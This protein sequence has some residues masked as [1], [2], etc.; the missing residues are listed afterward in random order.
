M[1]S[2]TQTRAHH[3]W[4]NFSKVL[5][6]RGYGGLKVSKRKLELVII[7]SETFSP[8]S[9]L[10]FSKIFPRTSA[11]S[12]VFRRLPGSSPPTCINCPISVKEAT[13]SVMILANI[14]PK[15]SGALGASVLVSSKVVRTDS[16]LPK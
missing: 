8:F 16:K 12:P 6:F 4:M 9:D 13:F 1:I 14:R 10:I 5:D 2:N 15:Y 11:A 7:S 3:P